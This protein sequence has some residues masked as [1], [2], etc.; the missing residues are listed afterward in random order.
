MSTLCLLPSLL[1]H[2]TFWKGRDTEKKKYITSFFKKKKKD[3]PIYCFH[4]EL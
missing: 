2:A 4:A 3:T 1:C